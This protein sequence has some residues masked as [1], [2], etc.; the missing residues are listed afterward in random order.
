MSVAVPRKFSLILIDL[1][2][3]VLFLLMILFVVADFNSRLAEKSRS[4]NLPL[5]LQEM[6]GFT[7]RELA[8][9]SM[10]E[11]RA[12]V[13]R[14][15][16]ENNGML[17]LLREKNQ[18]INQLLSE[19]NALGLR[20]NEADRKL[21]RLQGHVATRLLT[22]PD[23]LSG[24][25][26][27]APTPK[28]EPTPERPVRE[29]RS[30]DL[31]NSTL[32][33]QLAKLD[34]EI[35]RLR[36]EN[37]GRSAPSPPAPLVAAADSVPEGTG[38]EMRAAL[39]AN[40]PKPNP[41]RT[42][43]TREPSTPTGPQTAEIPV[44]T[45]LYDR[46]PAGQ[47][48]GDS[49]TVAPKPETLPPNAGTVAP[50]PETLPPNAGIV[51]PK[52]ETLPPKLAAAANLLAQIQRDLKAHNIESQV[53]V[54][55]GTIHLPGPF[56]F[57]PGMIHSGRPGQRAIH[58]LASVLTRIIPC[59][60]LRVRAGRGQMACPQDSQTSKL[61]A[62]VVTGFSGLAPVGSRPFRFEWRLANA[63][64]LWVW[65]T[66]IQAQPRLSRLRNVDKKHLFHIGGRV[67]H[68][69]D[70]RLY[71]RVKLRLVMESL[72]G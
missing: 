2:V 48:V 16:G 71:R 63:R 53:D 45:A 35:Q 24:R 41:L 52:P 56:D 38:P 19:K 29:A 70:P 64:S 15:Q 9:A 10:A 60:V 54:R 31:A 50:K 57:S 43:P 4:D 65:L 12:A 44:M 8:M 14:L 13:D 6:G 68:G 66:M 32:K 34:A 28:G 42:R 46:Q 59:Y 62:V 40:I 17:H 21:A 58:R 1:F 49:G 51:A 26:P 37:Q 33:S 11:A 22:G 27:L 47:P 55:E 18:Q 30:L 5:R 67:V 36:R 39:R 20:F 25:Q 23:D 3:I 7:D 61:Q 72:P 69:L